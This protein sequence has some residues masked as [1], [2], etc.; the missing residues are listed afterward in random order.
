[1]TTPPKATGK[2]R[3]QRRSQLH[4][5]ELGKGWLWRMALDTWLIR[6]AQTIHCQHW[7]C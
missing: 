1:M 6:Y 5:T 4:M 2:M 3:V 7:G